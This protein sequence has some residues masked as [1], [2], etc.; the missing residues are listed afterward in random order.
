MRLPSDHRSLRNGPPLVPAARA[1]LL[2]LAAG[3]LLGTPTVAADDGARD[4]AEQERDESLQIPCPDAADADEA[5][6]ERA[7]EGLERSV[8]VSAWRFDSLFGNREDE[9][10]G[11]ARAVYGRLRGGLIWDERDGLDPEFRLRATVPL[12]LMQHRL[13]AVVGRETDEEFIEDASRE[14]AGDPLLGDES[15]P[16]WLVG[17]GYD[18]IRGR[19]SRLSLGTGIKL[20][21]PLNPYVK[22]AYRYHY[23]PSDTVLLRAQETL[24]WENEEGFGASTR[25]SADWLLAEDR[26]LR[27]NN[28]FKITEETDGMYWNSNVTLFQHLGEMRAVALKAGVRGETGRDYGPV[29]YELRA[30]FRRPFL[31]DWLFVELDA[32]G[33]WL[34]DERDAPREFVPFAGIV[35]EMVF[36]RH[37][38]LAYGRDADR[39]AD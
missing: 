18:P 25:L 1:L 17:L 23:E 19:N 22:A 11:E 4:A 16:S 38:M 12:P 28:Y 27:W 33:R 32:G 34:R 2:G 7:R 30:I 14:F 39:D 3:L 15:D 20:Q 8:C 37:P 35:L 29:A 10:I 9:E 36:G 5:W 6:L 26:L 24:F 21:S 13:R 31:R